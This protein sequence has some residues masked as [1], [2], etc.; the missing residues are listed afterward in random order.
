MRTYLYLSYKCNCNC[1]FCASDETNVVIKNNEFTF[2]EAK[3]FLLSSPNREMLVI[4]GGEPTIHDDFLRIV[5]FAHQQY[6]HISLLTNGIKFSDLNYLQDAIDAGIDTISI[7]FYSADEAE[8]NNMVGNPHAYK[9]VV[10]CL[11]N[12]NNLLK[13]RHLSV[14]IKLLLAKFTYKTIPNSIDFIAKNFPNI[15]HVSIYGFH[16]GSKALRHI[17]KCLIN[18]NESRL[19]NDIAVQK[20]LEHNMD[21]HICQIPFCAFS[22]NTNEILIKQKRFTDSDISFMKR[23]DGKSHFVSPPIHVPKECDTCDLYC[24][25]PKIYGKNA[26]SF[27]YGVRSMALKCCLK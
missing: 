15:K 17:D 23:P 4:S 1:F 7:P 14:Q 5:E 21:F 19:Y 16:I 13:T 27:E 11:L 9:N 6:Q 3:D 12:L 26:S 2:E 20:L 18:Y 24:Y 8:H 25:C 22:A 10:K